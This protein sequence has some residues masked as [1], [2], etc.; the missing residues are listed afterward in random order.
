[1]KKLGLL[2]L[3]L[4]SLNAFATTIA[5]KADEATC[6]KRVYS[7][8][9]MSANPDQK[10]KEMYVKVATKNSEN[11]YDK[12]TWLAGEVVG[13]SKGQYYGNTAYCEPRTDG[14]VNCSI[15]CDG[16]SFSLRNSP[17]YSGSVNFIVTKDY[18]FPLFKNRMSSEI[19]VEVEVERIDLN[20]DKS[21][22]FR[23]E[24]VDVR[25]CDKAIQ[26]ITVSELGGC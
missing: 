12:W 7:D 18:Y 14:S 6:F 26:R 1:M 15:D 8:Q 16:G 13:V 22:I 21:G 24:P 10:L 5:P 23:L 19:E 17:R 2:A 3:C 20:G 25:E 11:Q 9:H 4:I